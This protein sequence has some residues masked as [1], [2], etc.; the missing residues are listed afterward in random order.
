MIQ[1]S[2]EVIDADGRLAKASMAA[3]QTY[4][5]EHLTGVI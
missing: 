1:F 4:G 5:Y 3:K 2:H